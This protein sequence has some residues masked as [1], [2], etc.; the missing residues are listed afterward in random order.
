MKAI[1]FDLDNTLLD[2]IKFKRETARAAAKAIRKAGVEE[3]EEVLYRAIFKLYS[4][5][6]IEYQNTLVLMNL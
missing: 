2:F 3:D 4:E 1:L 6:G 5:K